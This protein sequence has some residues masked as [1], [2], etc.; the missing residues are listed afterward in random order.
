M[1]LS[2]DHKIPTN[3]ESGMNGEKILLHTL[4][5]IMYEYMKMEMSLS[6]FSRGDERDE[7]KG[8]SVG[9]ME[10]LCVEAVSILNA[11]YAFEQQITCLWLFEKHRSINFLRSFSSFFD[12]VLHHRESSIFCP[13]E[14]E[15]EFLSTWCW[16]EISKYY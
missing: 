5:A 14:R 13:C 15:R 8:Q 6:S 2:L 7:L 3:C 11:A 10:M 16:E 4:L 1:I 9:R 12:N